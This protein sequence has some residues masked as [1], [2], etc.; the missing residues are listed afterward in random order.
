[1]K[2]ILLLTLM[3]VL[4]CITAS[5]DLI[6]VDGINYYINGNEAIVTY[7]IDISGDVI[8]PETI[9]YNYST[10]FC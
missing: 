1:M 10:Y 9:T 3:M 7:N 8:I 5:A 2:K 6:K 4:T